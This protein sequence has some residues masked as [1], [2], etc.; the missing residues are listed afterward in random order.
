MR[1][2]IDTHV[3]VW[4]FTTPD[5]LPAHVAALLESWDNEIVVSA[6][7]G[8]EIEY[9]R[10][11]DPLLDSL[12][13]ELERA[14]TAEGFEW[15]SITVADMIVAGRLAREHRD[16]WDRILAAQCLQDGIPLVSRD[17]KL[18]GFGVTLIW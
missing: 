10:F 5:I 17:A 6:I 1:L 16:P 12:P 13:L 15:R 14:V 7:T 11:M 3:L 9:K 18:A 4:A 8:Y 2:L